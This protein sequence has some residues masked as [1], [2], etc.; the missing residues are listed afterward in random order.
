MFIES[1]TLSL[2]FYG[3]EV[4][5][6]ADR[7]SVEMLLGN[8]S[9]FS[10]HPKN[11]ILKYA[12]TRNGECGFEILRNTGS[13]LVASDDGD[14]LF[15]ME[16]EITIEVQKRRSD[17]YFLHAAVLDHN[18]L[19]LM[20]VANSGG[21][22]ST[23]TWA[24]CHHGFRYLS[25]EL[26]PIDLKTLEVFPY[27]HALSL[28]RDPPSPYSLPNETIRTSRTIHVPVSAL[29]VG[30]KGVRTRL[31]AI[32]FVSHRPDLK[33]PRATP[34]SR[35]EAAARLFANALNPLAHAGEGLDGV[36]EIAA[37]CSSFELATNNLPLT[38]ALVKETVV[39]VEGFRNPDC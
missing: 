21:G 37:R 39:I 16:K 25:D 8:Y 22:K 2:D 29:P 23:T 36:L 11:P 1:A 13:L 28:K 12:V 4:E 19:G 31:G 24:L 7:E 35:T 6:T 26:A 17:L 9:F 5:I 33:S 32:F 3:I 20:L 14:F 27:A 30:S 15:Q 34:I 18:G 10:T 38:C